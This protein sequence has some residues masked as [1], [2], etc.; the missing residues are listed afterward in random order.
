MKNTVFITGAS[1]GLGK[2]TAK[3][4][5]QNGWNIIAAMRAPENETELYLL[6]NVLLVQLDVT[7]PLQIKEAIA[8]GT[9]KFGSLDVLINSAG[10][11]LM[12]VFESSSPEQIQKQFDVN[13]F[14]LMNVTK[15]VLPIMRAQ[16]KG[17]IINIS[18][19]GGVTA[20]PFA[21]LYNSSKFAVEGFSEALH[22]E[23]SVFGINVKIVEPGSIAT[24]FRN[25]LEMIKNEIEDYNVAL[26]AFIPKFT[27][28]TEH[29]PKANAEQVAETILVAATDQ[30]S[31]L[32]YVI[33]ED[34]H[35]YIDL[36]NKN[37]EED[38]L[39][40]MLE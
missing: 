23:V 18:S 36:K 37:S 29:L 26:S 7:N 38:F 20:G 3:L 11:G 12:G 9:E 8:K 33:G 21:S 13:V 27:K 40:L 39:R 32:R 6:E 5:Q 4:F 25:S 1:S 24:N 10:Y 35:L 16:K 2:A 34:A 30:F 17:T 19:F 14:G 15:A 31:K 28:R 22:F